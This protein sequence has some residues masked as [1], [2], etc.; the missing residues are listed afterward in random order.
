MLQILHFFSSKCSLFHNITF[1]VPVLFTFYIQGVQK[2]KKNSRRQSVNYC[3]LF[4][5]AHVVV[6]AVWQQWVT[7]PLDYVICPKLSVLAH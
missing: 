5:L 1:F 7:A 4:R 6:T 2:L 3:S